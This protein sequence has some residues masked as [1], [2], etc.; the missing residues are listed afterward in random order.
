[1]VA[2]TKPNLTRTWASGAP[3][4]NVIDPDTTTPGKF[5]AGWLAEVP[6]FEHFNF[7]QQLFTQ[8]LAHN[9]EQGIN[10]WDTNTTY[11]VRGLVKGSDGRV[12]IAVAEQSGN[13]PTLDDSSNW[14]YSQLSGN[15]TV[16]TTGKMQSRK[17]LNVG[18]TVR[19]WEFSTGSGGGAEYIIISGS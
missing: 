7:L 11:P 4:S 16:E 12:Y 1:M 15:I 3:G 6:P 14:V 5:A 9:N 8:G 10:V 19:T 2:T 18:D 13:D 17:G